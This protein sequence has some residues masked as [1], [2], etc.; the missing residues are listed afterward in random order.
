MPDYPRLELMLSIGTWDAT[1]EAHPDTA[2]EG[3]LSIPQGMGRE[4]LAEPDTR[5]QRLADDEIREVD[6]WAGTVELLG[7][8]FPVEVVSLGSRYL[9]GR[10]VLDEMEICFE[11][12]ENVQ[13]R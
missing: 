6:A 1:L 13:I 9:L 11:F 12:G 10:E 4:V 2:F 7:H 8:S 3:G 5:L